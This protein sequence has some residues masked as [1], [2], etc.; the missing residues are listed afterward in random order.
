M[1]Y[2]LIVL[3]FGKPSSIGG[4]GLAWKKWVGGGEEY[5]KMQIVRSEE[6]AAGFHILRLVREDNK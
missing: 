1:D 5:G 3:F 2:Y 6:A 4:A